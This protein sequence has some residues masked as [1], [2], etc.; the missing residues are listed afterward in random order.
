MTVVNGPLLELALER[1]RANARAG[2]WPREGLD[3]AEADF[4]AALHPRDRE[5]RWR[6]VLGTIARH[7][8]PE[9]APPARVDLPAPA[10]HARPSV[11]ALQ[12]RWATLDRELMPYV[13]NP[14]AP[15]ARDIIR[16]QEIITKLIHHRDLDAGG[17]GGVGQPGGPLDVLVVGAGPAGLSAAIYGATEGLDTMLVDAGSEP[18]GQAGLSSRIENVLGFPAGVT[19]AQYASMGLEQAR[20]VG[21]DAQLGVRA[22]SLRYD[23]HSGMKTV[24]LSDGRELTARSVVLAGGVQFRRLDFPGSDNPAVVY[25]D[26]RALKERC[27]GREAVIVG[28]GNSAGQA[29]IDAATEA[30]HV[31]ILLRHGHLEDRMSSYLVSQ[32][33]D[34]P[35]V[36]VLEDAEVAEARPRADGKLG[37]VV[38]RDGR[39]LP[40]GAL[41]LFVGSA[42]KAEWSGVERDERGYVRVGGEGRGALETS[43]PGVYAAGDLRAGSVHRVITAA[44]DGAQAI[45]LAH[46]R[47]GEVGRRATEAGDGTGSELF[48]ELL[49]LAETTFGPDFELWP[50]GADGDAEREAAEI[51]N[52]DAD[53]WLAAIGRLDS[54]APETGAD[55]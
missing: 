4:R 50:V 17:P 1:A 12:H 18:G 49:R 20:R 36:T 44:A 26:S 14:T 23:E 32:I 38:L 33:R 41:G 9:A 13:G 43:V 7:E 42:P 30:S 28:G 45:A 6:D 10:A 8:S 51:P 27:D 40:A 2:E 54:E 37:T 5:G 11:G 46:A 24:R 53:R 47:V 21:A 55:G 22:T 52:D 34:D 31:T 35:N 3:L 25:G 15:A 19:G 39:E 48:D 29:A 16:K